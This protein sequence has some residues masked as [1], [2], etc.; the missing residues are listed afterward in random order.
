MIFEE[1]YRQ[2]PDLHVVRITPSN[3]ICHHLITELVNLF[4]KLAD[5]Q[6]SERKIF[7]EFQ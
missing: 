5:L 7:P 1:I 3:K 4:T 6:L 2:Q